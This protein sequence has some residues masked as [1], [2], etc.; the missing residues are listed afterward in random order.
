MLGVLSHVNQ[1]FVG[2]S[3]LHTGHNWEDMQTLDTVLVIFMMY[4]RLHSGGGTAGY[5]AEFPSAASVHVVVAI[6]ISSNPGLQ[7]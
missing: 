2:G 5:V 3:I 7:M 1:A 6:P 4:S